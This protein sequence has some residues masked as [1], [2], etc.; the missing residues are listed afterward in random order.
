MDCAFGVI[1]KPRSQGFSPMFSYSFSCYR[2]SSE[3]FWVNFCIGLAKKFVRL[4]NTLFN[5][6]LGENEKCLL[7]LLK[8]KWAFWPTQYMVW[9]FI[10]CSFLQNPIVLAPFVEDYPFSIELSLYFHWKSFDHKHNADFWI[11]SSVPLISIPI[12]HCLNYCG[13]I[14][15]LKLGCVS[16][17]LGR[18]CSF[19]LLQYC[20]GY[21]GS[22]ASPHKL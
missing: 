1:S 6:V 12:C 3:A 13:F 20:F 19:V 9:G 16:L 22:F 2:E 18:I 21:S 10:V 11:L 8:T 5:T 4:V 15:S 7:F 17:K 14:V